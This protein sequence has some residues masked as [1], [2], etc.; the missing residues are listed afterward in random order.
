MPGQYLS[1]LGRDHRLHKAF[2]TIFVC[3]CFKVVFKAGIGKMLKLGTGARLLC[4]STVNF[5][6]NSLIS[7]IISNY[8]RQ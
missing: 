6:H 8:N 3:L 2:I 1:A 4:I 5:I 7:Q